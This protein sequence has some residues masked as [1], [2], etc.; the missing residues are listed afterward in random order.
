[1]TSEKFRLVKVDMAESREMAQRFRIHAAPT[2]LMFFES[3]LV[4]ATSLG[5]Q[6]IRLTPTTRNVHLTHVM[7]HPPRTLLV[8]AQAK[9]QLYNEKLLKKELFPWDLAMSAEQALQRIAKLSKA[10]AVNGVVPSYNLVLLCD[11]L[12]EADFRILERYFRTTD[13]KKAPHPA[14]ECVVAMILTKPVFPFA[15]SMCPLCRAAQG[16]R[17]SSAL[18]LDDGVCPHCGI[19]PKSF[20]ESTTTYASSIGTIVF[21]HR[22]LRVRRR[23]DGTLV[24][25][26]FCLD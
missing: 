3:K 12:G 4:A 5:G 24:R 13:A 20:V 18:D 2:F 16:R 15:S 26:V 14:Q 10:A 25:L 1:M 19:V 21:V 23:V 6:P 9:Q 17:V 8:Q 7:D 22:H 11:D